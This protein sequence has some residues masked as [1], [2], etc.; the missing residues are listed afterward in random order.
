MPSAQCV[1]LGLDALLAGDGL[2]LA[3]ARAGV[4]TGALPAGGQAAPV[5]LAP[6]G[7]DVLEALDVLL[8]GAP[9]GALDDVVAVD[10]LVDAGEG[11]LVDLRGAQVGVDLRLGED[12]HGDLPADAVDVLQREV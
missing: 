12:V 4:G 9:E 2:L 8:H 3:L 1:L 7:A 10:D 6:V 11:R 5:T